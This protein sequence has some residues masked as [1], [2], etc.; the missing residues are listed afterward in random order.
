MNGEASLSISSL[1]FTLQ[2]TPIYPSTETSKLIQAQNNCTVT[3]TDITITGDDTSLTSSLIDTSEGK[4]IL[5]NVHFTTFTLEH[6]P[7][8]RIAT[9]A[10]DSFCITYAPDTVP[11]TQFTDI[12]QTRGHG[13]IFDVVVKGG[14]YLT[15]SDAIF[16]RCT[17]TE[18]GDTNAVVAVEVSASDDATP[19]TLPSLFKLTGLSF[20]GCT[21]CNLFVK[22][23][24]A[25]ELITPSITTPSDSA[26]T[27]FAGTISTTYADVYAHQSQF[28]VEE[29]LTTRKSFSLSMLHFLFTPFAVSSAETSVIVAG[30]DE[31]NVQQGVDSET[32]GWD[33]LPCASIHY[34]YEQYK[35]HSTLTLITLTSESH[36][37][38]TYCTDFTTSVTVSPSTESAVSFT[39]G[40]LTSGSTIFTVG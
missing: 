17:S 23:V 30:Q 34:A 3:L 18:E 8:L 1:S 21:Q 31:R 33:D 13:V 22:C 24:D 19:L 25:I 40:A 5:Q 32:C 26:T 10:P 20:E 12:T 27:S 7:L 28:M 14:E 29:T 36:P 15:I 2:L 39:V 6:A 9:S 35:N 4:F 16:T 37:A 38:E 11:K